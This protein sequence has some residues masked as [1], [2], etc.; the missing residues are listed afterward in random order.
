MKSLYLLVNFFTVLIPFIF[1]FHPR[2]NFYKDFKPFF[3]AN[4]IVTIIFIGWD[5]C[6]T[7]LGVWGF[8]P[9]YVIGVYLGNLPLEEVLFFICIPFSCVFTYHCLNLFFHPRWQVQT[10]WIVVLVLA[11]ALSI[12]AIL[13]YP[14]LYTVVTF[15]SLSIILLVLTFFLRVTWL[16][17]ILMIY[18]V[19]LIPFC[20]VNGIL[21]G[22]WI[23]NPVV[24]YNNS[25]NMGLRL[26]TIPFEDVFY[27]LELIVLNVALFEYFKSKRVKQELTTP[28]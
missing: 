22:S 27:G 25:E 11:A 5:I 13:L 14:K 18:P 10:E 24:W 20:I 7:D 6:F 9:D 17:N 12:A 1:S 26:L 8:N 3:Q 16:P 28:S 2:L 4:I 19:L 21:T 15:I 23:E